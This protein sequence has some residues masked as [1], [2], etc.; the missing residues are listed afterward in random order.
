MLREHHKMFMYSLR[1]EEELL[2]R[3]V[4]S[5]DK[6]RVQEGFSLLS[7]ESRYMRFFSYLKE[8]SKSQ[9][10]YL[11]QVDQCNHVA[12]GALD[13]NAHPDLGVGIARFIRLDNDTCCAEL[14]ITV[15]DAYQ[16]RGIGNLLAAIMYLLAKAHA[17][18]YFI[19][20]VLPENQYVLRKLRDMQAE[21]RFDGNVYQFRLPIQQ[22][23]SVWPDTSS[24]ERF[25]KLLTDIEPLLFK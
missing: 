10:E 17:L 4:L 13:P 11:T 5:E 21:V 8:L 18:E 15:I 19:G 24:M 23:V 16:G 14:A 20:S 3:T 25:K 7:T 1:P 22:D 9:L 6:A 2:L 12:W